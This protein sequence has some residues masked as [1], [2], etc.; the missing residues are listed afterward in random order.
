MATMQFEKR[1]FMG[2][3]L[4]VLTGHPGHDL[5]FVATQAVLAAGLKAGKQAVTHTAQRYLAKNQAVKVRDSMDS[6]LLSMRPAGHHAPTWP[7]VW[8]FNEVALYDV[9]LRGHSPASEPFRKWV[10]EEVLPSIRKTGKYDAEQST[11]PIAQS[12]MD[13]LKTLRSEVGELKGLLEIL[14]SRPSVM[15]STP[16]VSVY[17]DELVHTERVWRHFNRGLLIEL[18]E[19]KGLSVPSSDK[20][21]PAVML[22]LEAAML[23]LWSSTDS[24]K[25]KTEMSANTRRPWALFPLEFLKKHMNRG[26]YTVAQRKSPH[27]NRSDILTH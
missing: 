15:E 23:A 20:L 24:R 6:K 4:D 21:K 26:A 27:Y 2:I 13:E 5:L 12:V 14:M 17:L 16:K 19:A 9:L 25:L 3:E 7:S 11:N 22:N 18:C 1:N 10:T 8:L